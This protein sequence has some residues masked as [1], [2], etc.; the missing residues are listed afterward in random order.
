MITGLISRD[1]VTDLM[2]RVTVGGLFALLAINLAGDFLRTGRVT[3]LL[4]LI[5]ESMV[6][7]LTIVRRRA[8]IVD[9]SAAATLMTTLSLA[10]PP[11][12]R[13][14]STPG[15]VPDVITATMAA[16]GLLLVIVGKLTLG[17][18]FGLAPANRGVVAAGP[19]SIVRHPI[20]TGYLVAHVA[21]VIAHPTVWNVSVVVIADAAL[22][23]R[24]LIEE[25]VLGADAE[26]RS[27]CQHVGWHLV[28]GVF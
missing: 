6:V 8:R 28:P 17:R 2:A 22:V 13:A 7:A 25:R 12:L 1:A 16:A 10:G 14:A 21:F 27:Y 3:G 11:L 19:Y 9:R 18:S 24:A 26:Y 15:E 20:Y 4:L 5:S 23:A